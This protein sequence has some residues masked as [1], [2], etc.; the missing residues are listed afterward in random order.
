MEILSILTR[1]GVVVHAIKGGCVLGD[2]IQSKVFAFTFSLAAEV[3][4]KLISSPTREALARKKAEGKILGRPRGPGK[5][6]IY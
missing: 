6:W 1:Q 2:D 3:E 4:R 5:I